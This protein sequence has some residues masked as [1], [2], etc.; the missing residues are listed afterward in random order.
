[1]DKHDVNKEENNVV[2]DDGRR[3]SLESDEESKN[4]TR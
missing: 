1:M 2:H 4:E 3:L